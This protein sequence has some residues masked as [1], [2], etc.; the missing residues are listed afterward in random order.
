MKSIV[1]CVA[2]GLLAGCAGLNVSWVVSY[3]CGPA[4]PC[5]N[6]VLAQPSIQAAP[7]VTK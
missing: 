2:G 1:L 6:V 3:N 7:V 5:Q 4:N